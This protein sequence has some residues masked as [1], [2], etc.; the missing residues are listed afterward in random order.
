MLSKRVNSFFEQ[1]EKFCFSPPYDASLAFG[2]TK[3]TDKRIQSLPTIEMVGYDDDKPVFTG[4][5]IRAGGFRSAHSPWFWSWALSRLHPN[6]Q[7]G[8]VLR[9]TPNAII[10][11]KRLLFWAELRSVW[12]KA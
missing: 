5:L 2:M 7:D 8:G 11:L 6:N 1:S 10:I 4:C 9:M 12:Q 3:S